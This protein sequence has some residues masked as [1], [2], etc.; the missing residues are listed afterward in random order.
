M[1]LCVF[2]T[3]FLIASCWAKSSPSYRSACEAV[4]KQINEQKMKK[5]TYVFDMISPEELTVGSQTFT[6]QVKDTSFTS[7]DENGLYVSEEICDST[8]L[9]ADSHI[10][11]FLMKMGFHTVNGRLMVQ[12]EKNGK[13]LEKTFTSHAFNGTTWEVELQ[14]DNKW[15]VQQLK[16]LNWTNDRWSQ[17]Y[18]TALS[19]CPLE[20]TAIGDFCYYFLD[21]LSA[22]L[23]DI[24]Q[25]R[26]KATIEAVINKIKG[27][28]MP[29]VE[30]EGEMEII[31]M[32][33]SNETAKVCGE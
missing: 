24:F 7:S 29:Q 27:N 1:S 10:I 28:N 23:S 25:E 31:D 22:R 13:W 19:D 17:K 16:Y 21:A 4:V 14:V 3:V 18:E 8:R 32:S 26:L 12:E 15:N 11:R 9:S 30:D 2:L 33:T 6:F 5:E 20:K